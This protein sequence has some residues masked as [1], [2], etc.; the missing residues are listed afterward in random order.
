M[1]TAIRPTEFVVG[2]SQSD[3]ASVAVTMA[4]DV[5]NARTA[6]LIQVGESAPTLIRMPTVRSL[7]VVFARDLF[8]RRGLSADA[9]DALAPDEHILTQD[10]VDRFLG[11]LAIEYARAPS[12]GRGSDARY[13]DGTT[14]A[15]MLAG[16]A[17]LG[18]LARRRGVSERCCLNPLR[19]PPQS[20][21]V[22]ARTR[23]YLGYARSRKINPAGGCVLGWPYCECRLYEA[24]ITASRSCPPKDETPSGFG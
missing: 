2:P 1:T 15:F 16:L 19:I 9:W 6:L 24:S 11:R 10:G 18:A 5:G 21:T 22:G 3:A 20:P 12:S 17:A 4:A 23:D 13:S 8:D 7:D 14:T